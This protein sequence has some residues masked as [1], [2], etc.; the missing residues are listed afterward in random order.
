MIGET[1]LERAIRIKWT[2]IASTNMN[3]STLG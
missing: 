1:E 3:H 2:R